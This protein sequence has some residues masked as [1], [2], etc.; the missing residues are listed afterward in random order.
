MGNNKLDKIEEKDLKVL[1]TDNLSPERHV[2]KITAETYKLLR[3]ISAAFTYLDK[4]V[5]RKLIV[6]LI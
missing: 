2:N 1:V 4:N 5:V 3:N 6:T